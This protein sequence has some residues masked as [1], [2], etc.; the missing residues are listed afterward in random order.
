MPS[1]LSDKLGRGRQSGDLVLGRVESVSVRTSGSSFPRAVASALYVGDLVVLACGDRYASDQFE[2]VA[3]LDPAKVR[4][5]WPV[6]AC[7]A[8][9]VISHAQACPRRRASSR[10]VC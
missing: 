7:W 1:R 4:R 10:L 8:V 5:C 6:V 9:C 2:G 3:E